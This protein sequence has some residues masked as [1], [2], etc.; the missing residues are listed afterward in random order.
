M[1]AL[2]VQKDMGVRS[3]DG[4]ERSGVQGC[5]PGRH[6]W[7]QRPRSLGTMVSTFHVLSYL[8]SQV[9]QGSNESPYLSQKENEWEA[10]ECSPVEWGRGN[11]PGIV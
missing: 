9:L 1:K 6:R 4:E 11:F 7:S 10:K 8:I 2:W 5:G 3:C